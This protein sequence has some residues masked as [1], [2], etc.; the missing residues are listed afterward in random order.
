MHR[1]TTLACSCPSTKS[2]RR[3][4]DRPAESRRSTWKARLRR[5]ATR[6]ASPGGI[7]FGAI[8]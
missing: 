3:L 4:T 8:G 6:L 1:S 5:W 2:Q 7:P